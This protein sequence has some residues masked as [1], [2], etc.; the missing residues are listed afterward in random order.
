MKM[1]LLCG[2]FVHVGNLEF[3]DILLFEELEEEDSFGISEVN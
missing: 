1:K 3:D 2:C